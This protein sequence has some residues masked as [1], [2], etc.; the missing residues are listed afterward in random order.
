[1]TGPDQLARIKRTFGDSNYPGGWLRLS[2]TDVGW[3]IG[4]VERLRDDGANVERYQ[5]PRT[6]HEDMVEQRDKA[7]AEVERLQGLLRRLAAETLLARAVI[8]ELTWGPI[9]ITDHPRLRDALRAWG[10]DD[11]VGT[12]EV[13]RLT[14]E[15]T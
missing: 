15:S 3:L 6:Q 9:V 14:S 5:V 7:R 12:P 8:H 10:A 2:S 13:K 11:K 4:E 1:V